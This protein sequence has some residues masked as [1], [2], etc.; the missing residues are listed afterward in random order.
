MEKKLKIV[1]FA[2]FILIVLGLCYSFWVNRI[3]KTPIFDPFEINY[4]VTENSLLKAGY[5]PI[6]EDVPLLGK[7]NGDTLIYY[8]MDYECDDGN[9]VNKNVTSRFC[10]IFLTK[11]DSLE[12]AGLVKK[13]DADIVSALSGEEMEYSDSSYFSID[14]FVKHRYTQ[15]IFECSVRKNYNNDRKKPYELV[16]MNGFPWTEEDI[17]ERA[18]IYNN[19]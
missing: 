3:D 13:Y 8:Q 17:K 19:W 9:C 18:W 1:V 15:A 11:I 6:P 12:M 7:Q 10:I 4:N 2:I 5:A 14:F 16:I